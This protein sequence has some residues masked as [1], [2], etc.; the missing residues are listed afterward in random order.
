[1]SATSRW[2]QRFANYDRAFTL[3]E[4]AVTSGVQSELEQAGL[5]QFFEF[6]FELGWKTL[7]DLIEEGGIA[8]AFPRD[9]IKHAFATGLITDGDVWLD[10]LDK[11][12]LMAHTYDNA[13]ATLAVG[14][15]TVQYYP[16]FRHLHQTLK[17]M[18]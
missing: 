17:A 15:I 2:K 1:M 9:V 7:K 3:L 8:A 6:T 5:I 18:L 4:S 16:V 13:K 12:N 14:L 11:R 10:M